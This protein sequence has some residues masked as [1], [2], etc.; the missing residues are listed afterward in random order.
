MQDLFY[1]LR[2][3]TDAELEEVAGGGE[4]CHG[5]SLINVENITV[6]ASITVVVIL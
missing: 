6:E 5:G 4:C 3:L 1:E 2:E